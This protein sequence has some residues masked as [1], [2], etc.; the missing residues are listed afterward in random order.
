[1]KIEME[2]RATH[3]ETAAEM[4]WRGVVIENLEAE[5]ER[6]RDGDGELFGGREQGGGQRGG[7][8]G[9]ETGRCHGGERG[10]S[11]G[12]PPAID[13]EGEPVQVIGSG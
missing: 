12:E 4:D 6:L 9:Q 7:Q 5:I 11:A 3:D 1:M 10:S 2:R 8:R 13:G